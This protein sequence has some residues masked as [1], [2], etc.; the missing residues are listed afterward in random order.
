MWVVHGETPLLEWRIWLYIPYEYI[1][2]ETPKAMGSYNKLSGTL[3]IM[4]S[5][6]NSWCGSTIETVRSE[7]HGC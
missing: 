6:A 3:G 1:A 5:H 7:I 4:L 2:K